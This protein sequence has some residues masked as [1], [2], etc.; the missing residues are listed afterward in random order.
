MF[1]VVVY[2]FLQCFKEYKYS[3]ST[4]N[5]TC[6]LFSSSWVYSNL[7]QPTFFWC[8]VYAY[9]DWNALIARWQALPLS[10]F[11]DAYNVVVSLPAP[12]DCTTIKKGRHSKSFQTL[13]NSRLVSLRADMKVCA[14]GRKKVRQTPITSF[15]KKLPW[16]QW[17]HPNVCVVSFSHM[18]LVSR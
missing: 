12:E 1:V 10:D 13:W 17:K 16:V 14:P 11:D 8:N 2:T 5:A 18:L 7:T 9:L 3:G 4:S 15:I 6:L